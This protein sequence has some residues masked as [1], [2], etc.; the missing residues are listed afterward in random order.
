MIVKAT[1]ADIYLD[2]SLINFTKRKDKFINSR[3]TSYT[4]SSSSGSHS[5]G[6]SSSGSSGGGH[7]SGGGRHG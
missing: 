3:T 7:S 2:M 1:N 5:G 6:G 4:V